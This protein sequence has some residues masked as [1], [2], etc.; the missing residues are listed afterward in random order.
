MKF[1][2]TAESYSRLSTPKLKVGVLCSLDSA[3]AWAEGCSHFAVNAS[4]NWCYARRAEAEASVLES[5]SHLALSN[6]AHSSKDPRPTYD[7]GV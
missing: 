2:S 3:Q 6:Y 5:S 7:S 1:V 4:Q